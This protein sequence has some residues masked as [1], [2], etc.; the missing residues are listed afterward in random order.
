MTFDT[1]SH[2]SVVPVG[3][4]AGK[5]IKLD[6]GYVLNVYAETQPSAGV[7]APNFQA[8]TGIKL[9]FPPSFTS[10]WNF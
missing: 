5:V 8:F 9:Q 10:N 3:F 1:Y 4:G 6:G 2:T 7:G